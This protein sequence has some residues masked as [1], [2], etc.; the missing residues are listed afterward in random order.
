MSTPTNVPQK[1]IADYQSE[2]KALQ[3]NLTDLC[4][5]VINLIEKHT[6]IIHKNGDISL[7]VLKQI[8]HT[9]NVDDSL[10][11]AAFMTKQILITNS[12][13]SLTVVK[14][15]LEL[16][17][18]IMRRYYPKPDIIAQYID[19]FNQTYAEAERKHNG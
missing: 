10:K 15:F 14:Q 6:E 13:M 7:I 5:T 12:W 19:S 11:L 9:K 16:N 3:K 8:A 1:T 18:A 17:D 4:V 2:N